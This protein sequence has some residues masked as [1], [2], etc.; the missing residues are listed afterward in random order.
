MIL[1]CFSEL[2]GSIYSLTSS[3]QLFVTLSNQLIVNNTTSIKGDVGLGGTGASLQIQN[4]A[5][6]SALAPYTG[7]ADFSGATS[8]SGT[9]CPGSV[10]GGLKANVSSVNTA[11]TDYN[12]L[13]TTLTGLSGGTSIAINPGTG[14]QTISTPGLYNVTSFNM[15]FGGGNLTLSGNATDQYVFRVPVGVNIQGGSIVL[16]GGLKPDN[17]IFL[18]DPGTAGQNIN[19]NSSGSFSGILL[20]NSNVSQMSFNNTTATD[21]G[22]VINTGGTIQFSGGTLIG[23]GA[24]PEPRTISLVAFGVLMIL[25]RLRAAGDPRGNSG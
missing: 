18:F 24:V 20:G 5:S 10:G 16:T 21:T 13:V 7:A 25:L 22:R 3:E 23:A 14:G 2:R 9:G 19:W 4:T 12:N 15:A 6:I 8:C 11:I 1:G 17:V